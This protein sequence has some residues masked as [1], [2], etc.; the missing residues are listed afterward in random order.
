MHPG[1]TTRFIVAM[2][3]AAFLLAA[4]GSGGAPAGTAARAAA[5]ASGSATGEQSA[6]QAVDVCGLLT[7]DEIKQATGHPVKSQEADTAGGLSRAPSCTWVLD[8]GSDLDVAGIHSIS[9]DVTR[10]GGREKFD[11]LSGL[12]T[13]SGIGDGA[14]QM[15]GNIGGDVW[16][17][18]GDALVHL[19]YALPADVTDADPI[20]LPLVTLALSKV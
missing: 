6:A 10:P 17:V 12:P 11:F 2:A 4:C 18:K 14:K 15:G 1:T 16:A 5:S 19:S 13:V 20:V 9:I 7:D 3:V 8:T